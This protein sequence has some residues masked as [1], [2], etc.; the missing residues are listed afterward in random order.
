[1]LTFVFFI[2]E[3][4]KLSLTWQI[5]N[6]HKYT[7]SE[8]WGANNGLVSSLVLNQVRLHGLFH[9]MSGPE[10]H[11]LKRGLGLDFLLSKPNKKS[12]K[13]RHRPQ[14]GSQAA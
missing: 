3:W 1:M 7:A 10:S 9:S 6:N 5:P 13:A 2:F 12:I 4:L 8:R 14:W 11:Q